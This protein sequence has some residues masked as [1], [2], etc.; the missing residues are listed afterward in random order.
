MFKHEY[1]Y[2]AYAN[3]ATTFFKKD[4]SSVKIV[5]SLTDSFSKFFRLLPNVSNCE[6][7]GKSVLKNVNVVLCGMN[8][9]DLTKETINILGRHISHNK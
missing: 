6:T 3:N 2:T 5:F 7:A 1:L 9:V 4:R 8:N